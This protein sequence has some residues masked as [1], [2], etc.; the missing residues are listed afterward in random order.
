VGLAGADQLTLTNDKHEQVDIDPGNRRRPP[1]KEIKVL[2]KPTIR[3][4][5]KLAA[6]VSAAGLA[7]LAFREYQPNYQGKRLSSWIDE[8]SQP[9]GAEEDLAQA[10]WRWQTLSNV[11]R[12]LGPRALPCA[13]RWIRDRPRGTM[14][15]NLKWQIEQASGGRI[16]MASRRDRSNDGMLIFELLGTNGAPAIPGLARLLAGENTCGLAAQCLAFVGTASVLALSNAVQAG[17]SSVRCQAIEALGEIGPAAEPAMPLFIQVGGAV[18]PEAVPALRVLAEVATNGASLL[19]LFKQRLTNP[20]TAP[21]AA[22]GLVRLG[23]PG[24]AVLL[25]ACTNDQTII[26]AAAEAALDPGIR[27][28]VT[29]KASR[30]FYVRSRRFDRGL[31]SR[32]LAIASPHRSQSEAEN[33]RSILEPY[34]TNSDASVRTQALAALRFFERK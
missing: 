13:I 11:V 30:H 20:T 1:Q 12:A 4:A 3:L 34:A 15:D 29:G 19:P 24:L 26:R 27:D 31:N 7:I 8:L 5:L 21:G 9:K 23:E 2:Q 17:S 18:S 16:R 6:A 32:M 25:Q 33:M 28:Y 22:Y 14:L 10:Q